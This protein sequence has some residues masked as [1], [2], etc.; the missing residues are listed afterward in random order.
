MTNRRIGDLEVGPIALGGSPYGAR[1]ASEDDA[2]RAA[3]HVAIDAG[4]TLIDSALAYT[5]L[6]EPA[7]A[8]RIISDAIRTHQCGPGVVLATKGGHRRADDSWP[9]DARPEALRRDCEASLRAMERDVI[10]VYYLHWPDPAIPFD[11]QVGGL[12]ELR[13]A[14]LI[15]HIGLSNVD[16]EQLEIATAIAPVAAVQ[17]PY[18]PLR[19]DRRTLRYCEDRG[20]AFVAYSPLGGSTAAANA[21][22]E[23]P[24]FA[25]V[26][27]AHGVST[28]RVILAWLLAQSP[29]M[30]PIAGATQPATIRDSASAANLDLSPDEVARL[31]ASLSNSS[32]G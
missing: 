2:S 24:A 8:D 31:T 27:T 20:I 18:S 22:R 15:R 11:E 5:S 32:S 14:G 3:I 9:K 30:I 6:E 21:D 16:V 10:D 26:A 7:H 4:M 1:D 25:E 13:A 28:Q 12:A 17:N 29:V 19:P 23:L